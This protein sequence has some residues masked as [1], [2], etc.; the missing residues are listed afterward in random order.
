M[1]APKRS[2]VYR[3]SIADRAAELDRQWFAQ[4]PDATAR[5]RPVIRSEFDLLAPGATLVLVTQ[6]A[7]G[8]RTR[9]ALCPPARG[10]ETGWIAV[11]QDGAVAAIHE[12]HVTRRSR[13]LMQH[14]MSADAAIAQALRERER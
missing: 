9:Q 7:P 1:T 2:G 3:S 12:G 14:G 5:L 11:G 13:E 8:V 4:H 10:E 6:L